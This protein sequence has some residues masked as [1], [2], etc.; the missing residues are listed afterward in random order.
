MAKLTNGLFWLSTILNRPQV[1]QLHI[2]LISRIPHE[3]ERRLYVSL[4]VDTL[5]FLPDP[6]PKTSQVAISFHWMPGKFPGFIIIETRNE[7]GNM[8]PTF[9]CIEIT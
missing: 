1:R 6:K 9:R 3:L 2:P 7:F 4:D 5:I 8:S